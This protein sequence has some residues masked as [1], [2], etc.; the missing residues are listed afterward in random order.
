MQAKG[1]HVSH[2]SKHSQKLKHRIYFLSNTSHPFPICLAQSLR[3][4]ETTASGLKKQQSSLSLCPQYKT[5]FLLVLGYQKGLEGSRAGSLSLQERAVKYGVTCPG[6]G[7]CTMNCI[8]ALSSACLVNPDA[9]LGSTNTGKFNSK[10]HEWDFTCHKLHK[11]NR[12]TIS[13][14]KTLCN[15]LFTPCPRRGKNVIRRQCFLVLRLT[16]LICSASVE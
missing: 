12:V 14:E 1:K 13:Q 2:E 15:H 6:K 8:H 4:R 16:G 11:L 9:D 3:A 7:K 5:T 10:S